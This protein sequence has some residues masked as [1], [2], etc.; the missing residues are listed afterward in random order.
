MGY[1]PSGARARTGGHAELVGQGPPSASFASSSKEP[2]EA[3]HDQA[4][5]PQDDRAVHERFEVLASV[6]PLQ[7]ESEERAERGT[8][9]RRP[10]C[11]GPA[12]EKDSSHEQGPDHPVSQEL[13]RTDPPGTCPSATAIPKPSRE[14]QAP[15]IAMT[16]PTTL[17]MEAR[18]SAP[19]LPPLQN[20][21]ERPRPPYSL[22]IG[23]YSSHHGRPSSV[24]ELA[25][26]PSA[27]PEL[28]AAWS[29][30]NPSRSR[31]WRSRSLKHVHRREA[32]LP[33]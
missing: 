10:R 8:D 14:G 24:L 5:A 4:D 11:P 16:P 1:R 21:H 13:L 9:Q 17:R 20:R 22:P 19:E 3:E 23:S 6:E 12:D 7:E 31:S 26:A 30:L 28:R 25:A 27:D 18:A 32:S 15:T 33:W 29:T 2:G